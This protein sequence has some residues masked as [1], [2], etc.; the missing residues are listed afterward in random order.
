MLRMSRSHAKRDRTKRSGTNEDDTRNSAYAI[1]RRGRGNR[2][3]AGHAPRAP[4]TE[5]E[6][7][8]NGNSV[9]YCDITLHARSCSIGS[10]N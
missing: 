5:P 2:E 10:T 9:R 1:G 6:R 8:V 7:A 3:P 4:T